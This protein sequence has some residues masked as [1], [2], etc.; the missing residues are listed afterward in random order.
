MDGKFE[1]ESDGEN[2]VEMN[3]N[4][5]AASLEAHFFPKIIVHKNNTFHG[6]SLR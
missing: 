4:E 6:F 2:D 1:L 5:R 3:E